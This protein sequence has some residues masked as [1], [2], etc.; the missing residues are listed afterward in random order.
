MKRISIK[1]K[2][3]FSMTAIL[4]LS[5]LNSCGYK[6]N[7]S[8]RLA[9]DGLIYAGAS[10]ELFTGTIVDTN[11]VIIKISVVNGVKN[12]KFETF[13]LNGQIE[14][15][16]NIFNNKNEGEWKYYYKNGQIESEGNF[17]NDQPDGRWDSY[18]DN[19][20]LQSTGNYAGG[21]M[22]GLWSFYDKKGRLINHV[23]YKN[24]FFKELI[25]NKA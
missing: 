11:N 13:Y 24:G 12:G 16:G 8:Y 25:F 17:H 19:G 14:K 23:V 1:Y 20:Q 10:H 5:V 2:L 3:V 7:K 18:Y 6:Y 22:I 9:K 4:L 21:K 15:S